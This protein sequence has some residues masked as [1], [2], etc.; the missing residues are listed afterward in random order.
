[1]RNESFS[2]ISKALS[3]LPA[4]ARK[5]FFAAGL[6]QITLS[7]LDL[8]GLA[9]IAGM[10]AIAIHG[11][12]ST[13]P[14]RQVSFVLNLLGIE[15]F[16]TSSQLT[17]LAILTTFI[18]V[19]KTIVSIHLLR[20][21][22]NFLGNRGAELSSTLISKFLNNPVTKIQ[23]S[24]SQETLFSVTNGANS[25]TVGVLG[26]SIA[27]ISDLALVVV[28]LFGV[29]FF[30]PL[31][32]LLSFGIF[33]LVALSLHTLT[34]NKAK[35]LGA[36]NAKLSIHS[37]EQVLEV[38]GSFREAFVRDRR[39][40]YERGI[41]EVRWKLANV[42]AELTILPSLSKYIMDVSMILGT[43]LV[44][45]VQFSLHSA[46]HAV[47][48]ITLFLTAGTR[49]APALLRIQQGVSSVIGFSG[50]AQYTF[51]LAN[52]LAETP[53]GPERPLETSF[54]HPGFE[55]R[56]EVKDATYSYPNSDGQALSEIN[57]VVSPG[58]LVAICGSSGAGK[59]TLVDVL[60]G[61]LKLN[62]GEIKVS[63][64]APEDCIYRWP[65]AIG[66]VP[67][68][69]YIATG[70]IRKNVALGFDPS[71]A[72]TNQVWDCLAQANLADFVRSLP[73]GIDTYLQENGK[74]LSG[75]QR[76]RLSIAR[77]L[78]TNPTL[79]VMDEATS[80]LDSESEDVINKSIQL[81]RG[82][83]TVILIAHRLASVR[84]ADQ[85][86]FMEKGKL[87][88]SGTFDQVRQIA[89]N[90]D[91]QAKLLGL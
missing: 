56:L 14:G 73:Q 34:R 67:Q 59:S 69:A 87:F 16:T 25:V 15:N 52:E 49:L 38:M 24:P 76:Q 71:E 30:D 72:D 83:R 7:F 63:G 66:Y 23:S 84:N 54:S 77:A 79:L 3:L 55:P 42:V 35:K 86:L 68:E 85:V 18:F 53:Q 13:S 6:I 12:D 75:G 74:S 81:M 1:M 91:V 64:L 62:S 45:G 37:N 41:S 28:I 9:L 47:G 11:L 19:F 50:S 65:G 57:I 51:D 61:L 82:S 26:T 44:A 58:E 70:T 10:S 8:L 60:L 27:L 5:R 4:Y 78:Y 48:G 29:V 90:F 39:F 21:M 36:E 40:A 32:A 2:T 89:P 33:S 20:K 17:V 46:P 43:L 22:L 80:S 88:A 31:T